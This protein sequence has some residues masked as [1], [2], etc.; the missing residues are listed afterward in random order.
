MEYWLDI[1]AQIGIYMILAMSLNVICGM[2]GLLQLGH[3]GFFAAGAYSAALVSIYM[4]LPLLGEANL[5]VGCAAA[6][7]VAVALAFVIGLPCLRLRG[8]Y[9]A[10]ATLAFG[11]IVQK[12]LMSV[13]FPACA[14]TGEKF[15]AA[16]G[17]RL[18]NPLAYSGATFSADYVAWWGI[19]LAAGAT[20]VLLLNLKRSYV[21]RAMIC[22]RE[23]EI[24]AS[25]MGIPVAR[26]KMLAFAL[27]AM[28]AGLAG[29]LYAHY[30]MSIAPGEFNLLKSMEVLL[31]VVL[32]GLG[33]VTGAVLASII[34]VLLPEA[35]RFMP[36]VAGVSLGQHRLLLYA[37]LLIV[38]VRLA[39]N[40]LLGLRELPGFGGSR[41]TRP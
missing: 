35:L 12:V 24:V 28:F 11:E 22:I 34:L 25:A 38:L 8:D 15:G 20:Y 18:P 21:G 9:L 4:T 3:V 39:P 17:V 23:D 29:A 27:S 7:V 26:Y 6:M 31:I 19:L 2:T 10:I 5:L 37:I 41:R 13:E 36:S 30:S 14:L 40:G 33:S 1:V 16:T 32:G